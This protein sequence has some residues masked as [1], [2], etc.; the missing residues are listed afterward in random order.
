V[1]LDNLDEPALLD[2]LLPTLGPARLLITT[3]CAELPPERNL[4]PLPLN[5]FTLPEGR[6][7]LRRAVER[8]KD[9]PD[10]ALDRLTER[11]G[12][13]PLALHLAAACLR[14]RRSLDVDGYLAELDRVGGTLKAA[15][16][17]KGDPHSPTGHI[18]DLTATFELSWRML[19]KNKPD[20]TAR[21]LF[22]AA[23]WCAPN[24]PLPFPVLH[25]VIQEAELGGPA[26]AE[27]AA[28]RLSTVG[29]A[30]VDDDGL[31][32][33]PLTALY[34]QS[35]DGDHKALEVMGNAMALETYEAARTGFPVHFL[36]LRPHA[37]ALA[38]ALRGP[39]PIVSAKLFQNL[40]S[41]LHTVGDLVAAH[42]YYERAL[43]IRRAVLGEQHP[44][45][46]TSINYLG[47]LY[48]EIGD[49]PT[50]R[51]YYQQ[52]LSIRRAILGE[53]HSHTASSLNN[54]GLL[55]QAMGELPAARDHLEQ[56][57]KVKRLVLG[58]RHADTASCMNN[59]GVLL[60]AMGDL[61]AARE[62]LEQA[63]A[64][65]SSVLVEQHPDTAYTLNNL[66]T[67]LNETGDL[68][69]SRERLE[70]ALTIRLAVLGKQHLDTAQSLNNL[71]TLLQDMGELPKAREHL[72]QALAILEAKLPPGHP[73]IQLVRRNLDGLKKQMGE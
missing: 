29:L 72:E 55:L 50:A 27:Q 23:G 65:Q 70:Q 14:L 20:R 49:L 11:L 42:K 17:L 40:G 9:A 51:E 63:L 54:L 5:T 48:Q 73:H 28:A 68:P 24:T 71:G 3:R 47:M 61:A 58:D 57:L 7:Y 21:L 38:E 33:H 1:V 26:E 31:T 46:A 25:E 41:H 60:K 6:R 69:A 36:P 44:S 52:A 62:Y 15:R 37:A 53:Q 16:L 39:F 19:G 59:L 56:A 2:E 8:L 66:G 67:L 34:A 32:L 45:T 22:R 18:P 35:L 10:D 12:G 30:A 64:I 43:E 13:L 4:H